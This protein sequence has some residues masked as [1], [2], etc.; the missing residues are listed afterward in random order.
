[1]LGRSPHTPRHDNKS[2]GC[3]GHHVVII[4]AEP[5]DFIEVMA[6]EQN[7]ELVS[8]PATHHEVVVADAFLA[9]RD[10]LV[11]LG[12]V[13]TM[14]ARLP[15]GR[16]HEISSV[17]GHDAFLKECEQLRPIFNAAIGSQT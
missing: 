1:M 16:L 3:A 12:D 11:P 13:R 5:R 2:V 17:Y 6:R 7:I 14:V 15:T 10:Q 8:L 9:T 4:R